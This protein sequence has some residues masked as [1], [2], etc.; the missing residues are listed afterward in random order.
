MRIFC[1]PEC[2]LLLLSMSS[3][4]EAKNILVLTPITSP[5]H[6]FVFKPLVEGLVER[7]HS[8]TYWN[9]LQPSKSSFSITTNS[10]GNLRLLNFGDRDRPFT[11]LFRLLPTLVNYCRVVYE[12]PIFH[13]LMNSKKQYDLIIVDGFANDCTL[14]LAEALNLPFV[15]LSCLAPQP[16]LLYEIGS[17]LALE[18]FPNPAGHRDRMNLWQ[19]LYNS[20]TSVGGL[21][22]HRWLILPLLERVASQTLGINN[23]TSIADI[24]NRYLSLMLVNSHF[25]VNYHLPTAS[26]V[27]EVGGIHMTGKRELTKLSKE[28]S[29]FLDNSGDAGFIIVSFGSML[30]GD[31]LPK[32][33]RK[34][35]MSTFARLKQRVVWKWENESRFDEEGEPIPKNIKT[36]SWLPQRELLKHPKVRLFISHGG[37]LSQF[38]TVHHGVPSICLPVWADHPINAQK[39]EDDGYAIRI[40]W[41]DLTE[42]KL[43]NAIQLMTNNTRYRQRVKQVSALMHDQIDNPLDRAI[44]WIEYV[45]RHQGAP[46]LRNASRDLAL[47]QRALFDVLLILTVIIALAAYLF[48]RVGWFCYSKYGWKNFV[49]G[50]NKK[51]N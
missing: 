8:V 49:I 4:I 50:T 12:D 38:E 18:Q 32:Q 15:Y 43:Y 1:I 35:F 11:L 30:R 36:I 16:W 6:S 37:L 10:T 14:Y 40:N 3:Y 28:L 22:F 9:G 39:S 31:E 24:K 27:V 41:D 47:P 2:F 46:H 5:S 23:L 51:N 26:A 48:L 44:Y 20:L 29:S 7:G 25:S 42:E 13:Q 17:P 19:R 33:F 21:Y 45:I 34:I